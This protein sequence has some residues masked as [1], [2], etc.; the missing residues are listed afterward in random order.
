MSTDALAVPAVRKSSLRLAV[1]VICAGLIIAL[2]AMALR[3]PGTYAAFGS[4]WASGR[5]A[6]AGANPYA[7]FPETYR[8]L[9]QDGTVIDDINLNPPCALP[10]ISA[11][12]RLNLR[13][14]GMSWT[15]GSLLCL[16][17]ATA[18]LLWQY[19]TMQLRQIVWL[20][21]STPIV[22]TLL[23][24]QIYLFLM[25][26]STLGLILA[27]RKR[28]LA[29]GCAIGCLVAIK[30]TLILWPLFLWLVGRK[31]LALASS[32]A[33]G[34]MTVSVLPIYGVGVY[35]EWFHVLRV[36]NHWRLPTTALPARFTMIG[37]P[38]I[39]YLLAAALV[40]FVTWR[41][42]RRKPDMAAA[43]IAAVGCGILCAPLSWFPYVIFLMPWAV[44]RRWVAAT[45]IGPAL[46]MIP[47][48]FSV[49]IAIYLAAIAIFL[50][51]AVQQPASR[52]VDVG[53]DA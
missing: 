24:G 27:E 48:A 53:Q 45:T 32:A 31:K 12:S 25:L 6:H 4:Y 15:A 36:D 22:I 10:M 8:S 3:R 18:L 26:L 44:R 21:L 46:L 1:A 39:G 23:C 20:L 43:S 35:R 17:C 34:L 28:E 7:T 16:L 37:E 30:P 13:Q 38:I 5:A 41:M 2:A 19:P 49:T 9:A 52:L 50:Y 47:N 51:D 33:C 29:A 11:L 42:A 14:F 40:L